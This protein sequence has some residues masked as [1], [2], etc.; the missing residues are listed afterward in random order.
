MRKAICCCMVVAGLVLTGCLPK[1]PD[2]ISTVQPTPVET[3]MITEPAVAPG[4]PEPVTGPATTVTFEGAGVSS[5]A[6]AISPDG[7]WLAAV[8][9]DSGSVSLLAF[10]GLELKREIKVGPDPRTLTFSA[11]SKWLVV[12]N[13]GGS[14][15][16]VVD[17]DEAVKAGEYQVGRMPYAA[18]AQKGVLYVSEHALGRVSAYDIR[19][20]DLRSSL[21]LEA[22]PSGLALD[23]DA[24]KL[25]ITH[26]FSGEVSLI[27]LSTFALEA[28]ISTGNTTNISQF[29]LL[30]LAGKRAY[31]PQTRSNTTNMALVFDATVFPLVNVLDLASQKIVRAERVSLDMGFRPVNMPFAV[32]LD[33]AR[34]VLMVANAGSNDVSVINLQSDKQLARLEVGA[35]P[36][37]IVFDAQANR[38]Y[39]NNVLDGTISVID[40]QELAVVQSIPITEIPLDP[41][42]LLGKQLFHAARVPDLTTDRWISCAVC[43]F[44]G[45]MDGR[46]WLG[47][48]DGPRNTPALFGVRNTPPVHWS[49]DLDEL[50]DVELTVRNIQAGTGLVEGEAYDALG[51]PHAGLSAELDALAAFMASLE[52]PPSPYALPQYEFEQGERVFVQLGCESCHPPP[53]YTDMQLHDVGTGDPILERNSHGRGTQFDTPSLLGIWAT[54]PYFHDG[55]AQ[56]LADVLRTGNEHHIADKLNEK[57]LDTLLSFLLALPTE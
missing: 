24:Q 10:P 1:S 25:Y 52:V 37:G 22:F 29:I 17:V 42:I 11:D 14:S 32:A 19:T 43:H 49:G 9:P 51:S 7:A 55:S 33:E 15:V 35:N 45:G 18:I 20:G 36:R 50:Q 23:P 31:L 57:E 3:V 28:T 2:G 34:Q 26:L 39:V 5:S 12:S 38:A 6:L 47:F 48:P 46:T 13:F 21:D 40:M 54:A 53:L 30:S 8:N 27:D 41:Q 44:D 4:A 16:T 56:T